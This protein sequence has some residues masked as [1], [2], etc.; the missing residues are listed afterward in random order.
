MYGSS[1][2]RGNFRHDSDEE[3]P[4]NERSEA[5]SLLNDER[6]AVNERDRKV[7]AHRTFIKN[8]FS[9][10]ISFAVIALILVAYTGDSTTQDSSVT[11]QNV[12][13]SVINSIPIAFPNS[14]PH[15]LNGDTKTDL[16]T[17]VTAEI[18][19]P[20]ILFLT[21][22]NEYGTFSAAYPWMNDVFGTQLVEPYKET[23][24]TLSGDC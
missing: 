14:K 9:A 20:A 17:M 6:S 18:T 13:K 21:S 5:E 4:S 7:R 10:I 12:L 22:S 8:S 3:E 16:K 2:S 1:E 11:F 19:S 15:E 24:L 23:V